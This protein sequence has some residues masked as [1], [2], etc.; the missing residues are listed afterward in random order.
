MS[1]Q[2]L[3]QM[4]LL[5]LAS[6][7]PA[8]DFLWT[9]IPHALLFGRRGPEIFKVLANRFLF[10]HCKAR[11][12]SWSIS[13]HCTEGDTEAQR[14][15]LVKLWLLAVGERCLWCGLSGLWVSLGRS[16]C[17]FVRHCEISHWAEVLFMMAPRTLH[18]AA[19][20]SPLLSV[21]LP[22]SQ[23]HRKFPR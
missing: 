9:I 3:G 21:V 1:C 12:G 15:F 10:H 13:P 18:P 7:P 8:N 16:M 17:V 11:W 22:S 2:S 5:G 20:S 6:W 23:G 19:C 4:L 14:E